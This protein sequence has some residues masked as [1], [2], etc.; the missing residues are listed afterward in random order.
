MNGCRLSE[1]LTT[2]LPDLAIVRYH[3]RDWH[4]ATFSGQQVEMELRTHATAS[5]IDDFVN[6]L[7]EHEFAIS[8]I[9]VA[10]I[11]VAARESNADGATLLSVEALLLDDEN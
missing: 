7:S 2:M 5:T 9:L 11:V 6:Q 4:S 3:R 10:D 8:G 1:A